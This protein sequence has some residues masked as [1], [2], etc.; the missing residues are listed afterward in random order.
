MQ[1]LTKAK[2][3]R[4]FLN[5]I[6]LTCYSIVSIYLKIQVYHMIGNRNFILT[7]IHQLVL[8]A[9]DL[10]KISNE[11]LK[12]ASRVAGEIRNIFCGLVGKILAKAL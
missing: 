10:S 9:E 7:E 2:K 5:T 1:R 6:N 3:T 12:R 4:L 11:L 8:T